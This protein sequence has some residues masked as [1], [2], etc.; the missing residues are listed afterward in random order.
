MSLKN[1]FRFLVV[2]A[3]AAL[4]TLSVIW[5]NSERSRILAEKEQAAM[6]LVDAA[7]SIV[8]DQ[9]KLETDGKISREEAQKQAIRVI[10][11]MRYGDGNY[12]WINDMHVVMI[13]HPTH[14]ELEGKDL[15]DYR[16]PMGK[17]LFAEMTA[18]VRRSGAGYVQ[19]MW[20]K[21]GKGPAPVPKISYVKG[22]QSWGWV[23]GTGVYIDDVHAAWRANAET[24]AGLSLVCV[25]ILL[26]VS[27][28][29]SQSIFRRLGCVVQQM[30]LIAEGGYDFSACLQVPD[31]GSHTTTEGDSRNDEI[32]AMVN[33]FNEMLRQIQRRDAKLKRYQLDLEEE[34]ARQTEELRETNN[35][36]DKAR[37]A[38]EAANRAKSEFLANMSH[39]IR[40]PM[41]GVIGMTELALDTDMTA[42]Q[43]EYLNM[44]KN[45][46]DSLLSLLNDILDFSKIEAGKLDLEEIDFGLRDSLDT[47]MKTLSVRAHQKDPIEPR[48]G[49]D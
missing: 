32:G 12:V 40:T 28:R 44:A 41:N 13:M 23:I 38:A 48:A 42:E 10:R 33:G 35:R 18:I 1:N 20:P 19:Y 8:A 29:I 43:R 39:E 15:S 3:T 37:E 49:S 14:P 9:N 47:T 4:A 5:L 17:A 36:L 7:Y 25:L 24:A 21:P 11:A 27:T 22:F 2:I 34:V 26:F 6:G 45:S 46:A 30:R 16:D 31:E